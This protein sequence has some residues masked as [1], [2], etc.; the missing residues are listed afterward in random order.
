MPASSRSRARSR[1]SP[2]IDLPDGVGTDRPDR[3]RS[4]ETVGRALAAARRPP[5]GIGIAVAR[6]GRYRTRARSWRSISRPRWTATR[7]PNEF[8]ARFH[9]PVQPRPSPSRAAGRRSLVRRGP[10]RPSNSRS[11]IPA[12]CSAA[13]FIST[14]ISIAA[15]RR[16]RRRTRPHLRAGRRRG[17]PLRTARLLGHHRDAGL[18]A[19][20]GEARSGL[21][22]PRGDRIPGSLSRWRCEASRPPP[23]FS[24]AMPATSRSASPTCSRRWLPTSSSC[25]A[26]SCWAATGAA[27][28][29]RRT[30]FGAWCRPARAARSRSWRAMQATARLCSAPPAWCCPTCCICDLAELPPGLGAGQGSSL[31]QGCDAART[32]PAIARTLSSACRRPM[33]CRPTGRPSGVSPAGTE[34]AG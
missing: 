6:D 26:T 3:R 13:R 18:A 11:S 34:I 19:A 15:L 14:D 25:T 22:D 16:R 20:G 8:S 21:P 2:G 32:A 1:L 31:N 12:R 10:R 17:L 33:I 29:D 30:T 9:L 7:S 4:V 24:T 23:S 27:R 5:I 28:G